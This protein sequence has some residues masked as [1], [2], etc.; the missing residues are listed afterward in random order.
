MILRVVGRE[1]PVRRRSRCAVFAGLAKTTRL[2][3]FE[4]ATAIE[5]RIHVY[6]SVMSSTRHFETET[7]VELTKLQD[8][9]IVVVHWNSMAHQ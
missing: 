4:R 8:P 1:L 7:G 9:T 3:S 5:E 2:T 6:S